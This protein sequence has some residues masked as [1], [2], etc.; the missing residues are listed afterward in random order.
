MSSQSVK[1]LVMAAGTGGHVFPA[2]SIADVLR[3]KSASVEWLGTPS[4]MENELL[5]NQDIPLHRVAVSG[6][7]GS[8][9]S[10]RLSAP[11]ML[12]RAFYQSFQ[13]LREVKPDCVLGM[14]GFICGPA[15]LAAKILHTPLLIHEQNAV[16]GLTNRLLSSIAEKVFEAFPNTFKPDSNIQLTGNPLRA[17]I[18]C[19]RVKDEG[20]LRGAES[21]NVLVLGGSQGAAA[22][23][24]VVPEALVMLASTTL[25]I[26][27]QTGKNKIEET[28]QI[29]QS[30]GLIDEERYQIEPFI[31]DMA[32]AYTWADIV[33]CRSGASTV[34]EIAAAGRASVLIPYPYHKD[35]QQTFNANWLA[36][37]NA[38]Y[39]VQQAD[40]TAPALGSLLQGLVENRETLIE[41][42]RR[43]SQVA[44][45]D[46]AEVVAD[47][48]IRVANA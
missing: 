20:T 13:V 25:N 7:R 34:S 39:V 14:G 47:E 5:K 22:I 44:I 4:G 18:S 8:G 15:G 31:E 17:E 10:R 37:Q 29:Y 36:D 38:A 45:R 48:C 33:V 40:L 46:A 35:Q 28:R 42:G 9:I 27:H 43:A 41:M 21:L 11:F 24:Q 26:M 32:G 16:A 19:I 23:N 30:F 2:L 6:L 3:S 12:L 1:V